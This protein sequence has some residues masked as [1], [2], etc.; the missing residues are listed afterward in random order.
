VSSALNSESVKTKK[1]RIL[2][3]TFY[4]E[5]EYIYKQ[6]LINEAENN[7]IKTL[8][9]FKQSEEEYEKN[10]EDL[11]EYEKEEKETKKIKAQSEEI[12]KLFQQYMDLYSISCSDLPNEAGSG[13]SAYVNEKL[14]C[15]ASD[16]GF[17]IGF[18]FDSACDK[19]YPTL[20]YLQE[21]PTLKTIDN[22]C[23][24]IAYAPRGSQGVVGSDFFIIGI[25]RRELR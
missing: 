22:G 12:A 10:L 16:R 14:T 18:Y 19:A 25:K 9:V 24:Y 8:E 1:I 2:S 5:S 23:G 21:N 15:M 13:A 20:P 6:I 7:D 3:E 4:T 17:N 11:N